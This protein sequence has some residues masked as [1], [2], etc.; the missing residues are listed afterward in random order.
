MKF[1]HSETAPE[2]IYAGPAQHRTI[3]V[4]FKSVS[5]HSCKLI[6]NYTDETV[7]WIHWNDHR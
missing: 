1:S 6:L 4:Y 2:Q 5:W 3:C 7:I